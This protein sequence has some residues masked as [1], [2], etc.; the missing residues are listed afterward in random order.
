MDVLNKKHFL[1]VKDHSVSKEIFDLYHDETLDMLITSPQPDLQ[2]LGRYYE[3]EDYIS[4]TD[5]KRSLFEKAY[6]FVKNIALKN[7]LNLINGEQSKKGRILDIG[8]GTGDFLLTAKN[9]GWETVGV[10]PSERAKN[11]AIQKGISF[12][13]EIGDLGN[14]SFDVITMWHVLEHVPNLELQIQELKRLLKPTGT[15]IVAVPN[16]K[17]YDAKHYDKFWAAY[18]VPIHFWHFSKK[19]IQSL[20]EKVDMKLEKVLPMKF[21][22]F[23]V[24]LLSEKYKTGKMNYISAFFIGLKSNLKASSS[25]EYSSHIY[26]IKNK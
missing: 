21:D 26:V 18:D 9:N 16:F 14:N 1:T 24:S 20:F 15:L 7:K 10:E 13:N 25:K 23:Y 4:H 8:A 2:N 22:S 6:H 11:I 17:S 19:A 5:N 12:V 3:S